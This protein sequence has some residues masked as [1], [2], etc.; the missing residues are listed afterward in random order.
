MKSCLS[1]IKKIGRTAS[2][3]SK[4]KKIGEFEGGEIDEDDYD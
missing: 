1:S 4:Q 3:H 2:D